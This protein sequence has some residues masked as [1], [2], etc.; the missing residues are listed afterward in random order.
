[1]Y[2]FHVHLAD[3]LSGDLHI[4]C[5]YITSFVGQQRNIAT[6]TRLTESNQLHWSCKKLFY[7]KMRRLRRDIALPNIGIAREERYTKLSL[8]M[9]V[10]D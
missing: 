4:T 2:Y 7:A 8:I 6:P 5:G 1:M 3:Q 9:S 10:R